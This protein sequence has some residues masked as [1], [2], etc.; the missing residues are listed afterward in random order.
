[1]HEGLNQWDYVVAAL[2][3]GIAGTL[4]L[5]GWSFAAMVRAEKRR[6]KVKSK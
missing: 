1:M 6:D 2:A 4:L 3:I 5:V